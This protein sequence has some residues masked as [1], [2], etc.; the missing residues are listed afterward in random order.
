LGCGD[1]RI[2]SSRSVSDTYKIQGQLGPHEAIAKKEKRKTLALMG[3]NLQ[4][5]LEKGKLKSKWPFK[6]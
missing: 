4:V 5:K 6:G 2:G 1:K 3:N